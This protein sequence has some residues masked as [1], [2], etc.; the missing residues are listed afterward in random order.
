MSAAAVSAP[1]PPKA[2]KAKKT[3]VPASHPPVYE[4][5]KA[6]IV[7]H[8][9]KKGTSL[10]TIKRHISEHYKVDM[11]KLT[12]HIRRVL[13]SH[14]ANGS[15]VRVGNKGQGASGSFKL[16]ENA[17]KTSKVLK[18]PKAPKVAKAAKPKKA[19]DKPKKVKKPKSAAK[20]PKTPKKAVAKKP[21]VAKAKTP[22]K[23]KPAAT[24]KVHKAKPL[25]KPAAKKAVK[26]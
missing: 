20:K 22:K 25:K 12:P 4:M 3:K 11:V 10:P 19:S 8:K 14:V 1:A 6:A 16:G 7:A 5:I 23:S 15:L 21:K 24:P 9:D 13:V 18:A 26:A 17:A 2:H